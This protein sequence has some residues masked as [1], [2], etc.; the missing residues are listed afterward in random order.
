MSNNTEQGQENKTTSIL[1]DL[2]INVTGV[3]NQTIYVV[4]DQS[5]TATGS[6]WAGGEEVETGEQGAPEKL[7]RGRRHQQGGEVVKRFF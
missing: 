2:A 1:L 4:G 6:E 5:Q 3:I 7:A